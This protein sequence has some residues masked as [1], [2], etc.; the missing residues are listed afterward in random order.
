[1]PELP[2]V[3]TTCRG[4][5]MKLQGATIQH[6]E[7]NRADLRSLMPKNL[8]TK[9]KNR[10]IIAVRRRA[11]YIIIDLDDQHSLLIHLGMSGRMVV[12]TPEQPAEKHDHVVL[13]CDGERTVR[14]NDPRRFGMLDLCRTEKLE[15]H[16]LL[17]HL[18]VEPLEN[19]LTTAYL[20]EKFRD[21]KT[22][23][24][25]ALLDQTIIAGLGNIYVCEALYHARI[26][27]ERLAA[28][29]TQPEIT[30]LI[31]TIQKVLK[32]ALKAGGSSLRDYVQSDGELGYFQTKFAVYDHEGQRCPDCS[33]GKPAITRIVQSGRSTFFCPVLQK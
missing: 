20:T 27:P 33:C 3:E 13:H 9:L 15:H 30:T 29:L 4:L 21:K 24:K 25:S 16:K 31:P 17:I 8:P 19:K 11:K 10:Q 1:M 2:E 22:P 26:A 32:A 28:S 6:A 12:G 5:A 18:G 14:F 23:I 7:Q